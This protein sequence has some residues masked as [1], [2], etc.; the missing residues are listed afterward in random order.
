MIKKSQEMESQKENLISNSKGQIAAN[1]EE[2]KTAID[3]R[4]FADFMEDGESIDDLELSNLFLLQKEKGFRFGTDAVLLSHFTNLK[5][6]ESVIDYCS[7][8][9]II[10]HLFAGKTKSNKIFGVE[11]QKDYA[12]MAKRSV[13]MNQLED[14]VSIFQGDIRDIEFIKSLGKFDV[15]SVN[16]PYKKNSS[17]IENL[18]ES[19]KIARHEVTLNLDDVVK[20]ASVSLKDNGRICM[21]HRPERLLDIVFAFRKYRIEPKRIRMVSPKAGKEP[22]II[23]IEGFKNQKPNLRFESELVMYKNDGKLTDEVRKIYGDTRHG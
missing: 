5:N 4:R 10:P 9:G 2:N 14:R 3:H 22:N 17:G 1:E 8:S 23:L 21:V 7:G 18:D 11:I 6:R 20:A 19:L 15:V 13:L 16:P 12:D